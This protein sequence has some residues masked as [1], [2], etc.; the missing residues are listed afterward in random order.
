MTSKA[1]L[2]EIMERN[3]RNSRA[4]RELEAELA[5]LDRLHPYGSQKKR[6]LQT[7]ICK[8]PR[9]YGKISAPT[10]AQHKNLSRREK[11]WREILW[12]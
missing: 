2:A 11:T 8:R 5:A 1:E 7:H 3:E 12:T 6:P 10:I 9:G 4:Y